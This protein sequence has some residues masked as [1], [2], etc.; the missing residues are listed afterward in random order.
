MILFWLNVG[1]LAVNIALAVWLSTL[2]WHSKRLLLRAEE[3]RDQAD[4]LL[5]HAHCKLTMTHKPPFAG[6]V[7]FPHPSHGYTPHSLN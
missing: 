6:T 5:G 4:A 3:Q 7:H 2:I 1:V